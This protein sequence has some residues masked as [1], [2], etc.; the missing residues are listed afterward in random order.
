MQWPLSRPRWKLREK[1]IV[2]YFIILKGIAGNWRIASAGI[3]KN[4]TR[5]IHKTEKR[6][7]TPEIA[8][9]SPK[10]LSY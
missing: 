10:D 7:I 4:Q 5:I 9:D 1:V 2:V 3:R 8:G 6:E